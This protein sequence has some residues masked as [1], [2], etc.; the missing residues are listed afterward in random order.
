MKHTEE[1][2][3]LTEGIHFYLVPETGDFCIAEIPES[4]ESDFK[5]SREL[6]KANANRL[7]LCWNS[8]DDLLAACKQ[9]LVMCEH[10]GGMVDT[11]ARLEQAI[12]LATNSQ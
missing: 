4:Y 5:M 9:A 8:H 1:K 7:A 12:A 3:K 11:C 2:I 6:L 10:T